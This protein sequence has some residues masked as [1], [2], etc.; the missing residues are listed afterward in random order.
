MLRVLRIRNLA[1]IRELEI[2]FDRGLNLLTGETGSGKSILVDALGLLVGARSSP[3]LIRTGCTAAC[4]EGMFEIAPNGSAA[5]MLADAG[6]EEEDGSLLL[7]REIAVSGRN[8]IFV[9]NR[10]A[11]ASLLRSVGEK[12]TAIH[13]Q[14]DQRSLLDLETHLEWLDFFGNN[15]ALRLQVRD[16]YRKL[17][18]TARQIEATESNEQ[19]RL[20]RID[21]LQYQIGEIRSVQPLP[22]EIG[23]LEKERHLLTNR[24]RILAAASETYAA[25]YESEE[26]VLRQTGR[27]E[28]I[29]EDLEGF[30][31][32][33]KEHR[34]TVRECRYRLEDVAYAARDYAAQSDFSPDRLEQVHQRLYALEKLAKKYG[35]SCD[36]ILE[37]LAACEGELDRIL[38]YA[39]RS[40]HLAAQLDAEMQVYRERALRLSRKR[41]EDAERFQSEIE[42]EFR[43]LAMERMRLDVRFGEEAGETQAGKIPAAYGRDGIDRVEFLIAPNTGEESR[44]LAKIASGGELSRIMLAIQSL[45]R[46]EEADKT[47]VFD[48]VD[49]GIGGRV[50]DAVGR[51]LRSISRDSQVLCVTH[52]PQIAAYARSHFSVRKRTAE[53]RT[54]T[55]VKPLNEAERVRELSRMLGG[56]TIT[57]TAR[58]HAQEM[59]ET[60]AEAGKRK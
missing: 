3:D 16:A 1:L 12:L 29:L 19:E 26:S 34:E 35:A 45:C 37:Y 7:R 10:L 23:E 17:R 49:S 47:F 38:A 58:D 13:G 46:N 24:E 14:Q 42:K 5:A 31:P 6:F 36:D 55:L 27:V 44:S 8:R 25:L 60:A 18:E 54:E 56:E 4:V 15:T 57:Q 51:R 43:A 59:L 20:R 21:I 11:T 50:A 33:W 30:D 39:E 52:L 9:N 41:R 32:A 28:K 22:G 53:G 48:E 2:E 40:G